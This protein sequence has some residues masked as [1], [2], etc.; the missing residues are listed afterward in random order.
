[1]SF[2]CTDSAVLNGLTFVST[3]P[4]EGLKNKKY[5]YLSTAGR[6]IIVLFWRQQNRV[7]LLWGGVTWYVISRRHPEAN[8]RNSR[9]ACFVLCFFFY[10]MTGVFPSLSLPYILYVHRQA[11]LFE[12]VGFADVERRRNQRFVFLFARFLYV[13]IARLS[14]PFPLFPERRLERH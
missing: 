4:P 1:M 7:F 10:G 11:T 3:H 9:F 8:S 13:C 12:K 6:L 2:L 14:C 5:C